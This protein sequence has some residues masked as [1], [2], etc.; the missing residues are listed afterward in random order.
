MNK[1]LEEKIK[2]GISIILNCEQ[3][4]VVISHTWQNFSHYLSLFVRDQSGSDMPIRSFSA[5]NYVKLEWQINE[6]MVGSLHRSLKVANEKVLKEKSRFDEV[7][8]CME[9]NFNVKFGVANGK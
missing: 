5:K 1:H 6:W 4:N 8:S 2:K 7:K 9:E 3:K